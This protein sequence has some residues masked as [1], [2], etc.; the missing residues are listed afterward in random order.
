[1]PFFEITSFLPSALLEMALFLR[2]RKSRDH[3]R[4]PYNVRHWNIFPS[5][6]AS[7]ARRSPFLVYW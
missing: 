5:V 4:F 2:Y 7:E 3:S 6:I 1:M